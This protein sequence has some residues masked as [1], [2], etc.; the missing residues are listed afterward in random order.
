M[1][2]I[3]ATT[4]SGIVATADNTGSL[5]LQSAGTTVVTVG[6]GGLTFAANPGGLSSQA[7]NDYEYGTYTPTVTSGSGTIT[8]YSVSGAYTK[9]GKLVTAQVNITL[10]TVGTASGGMI[11]TLPFTN[12]SV[13]AVGAGREQNNTGNMI[14][15][16][17]G[18][19]GST[20]TC[21]YYN[22]TTMWT[23][24]NNPII[25]ITYQAAV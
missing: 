4:S 20:M 19:G 23:N 15:A 24:A 1:A 9:I 10:T 14:Q 11:V 8:T 5:A 6:S 17:V 13:A 12:G 21:Y 2:S 18:S 22:N 3:N 16:L 7:L 25:T